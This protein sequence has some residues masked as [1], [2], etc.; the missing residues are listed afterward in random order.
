MP[1]KAKAKGYRT[2]APVQTTTKKQEIAKRA[3]IEKLLT[4]AAATQHARPQ[5]KAK[6]RPKPVTRHL[7]VDVSPISSFGREVVP[8]FV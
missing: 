1:G 3:E 5:V 7:T 8:D 4:E 6:H 2:C